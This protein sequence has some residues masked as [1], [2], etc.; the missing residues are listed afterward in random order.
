MAMSNATKPLEDEEIEL[1]LPWYVTGR[2]DLADRARVEAFLARRPDMARQVALIREEQDETISANQSLGAAPAA[3]LDRLMAQLP[4]PARPSLSRRLRDLRETVESFFQAPSPGALR[5]VA[6][7]AAVIVVVQFAA[8][9][10]LLID[11]GRDGPTYQTAAGPQ[12]GPGVFALIG[13][14]DSAPA[15]AITRLLAEFEASIVEGPKP[16]GIYKIRIAAADTSDAAKQ[17]LLRRL[18]ERRDVVRLVLPSN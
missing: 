8:I 15:A 13:F 10:G 4:A 11:H 5:W 1:L 16:G 18:R 2:L 3:A 14:V 9:G 17:E 12:S 7:A 6:I